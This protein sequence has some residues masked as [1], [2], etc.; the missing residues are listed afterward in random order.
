MH[1]CPRI[2]LVGAGLVPAHTNPTKEAG[3][4]P[5]TTEILK[6]V[7]YGLKSTD[8]CSRRMPLQFAPSRSC[9]YSI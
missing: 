5:A 7:S 3:M 9:F 8:V 2:T 1:G 6:R 4:N